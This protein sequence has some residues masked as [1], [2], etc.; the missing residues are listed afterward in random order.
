LLRDGKYNLRLQPRELALAATRST[1]RQ[2]H[3][4]HFSHPHERLAWTIVFAPVSSGGPSQ[5]L[6]NAPRVSSAIPD[7]PPCRLLVIRLLRS[8]LHSAHPQHFLARRPLAT[9]PRRRYGSSSHAGETPSF[10]ASP[11]KSVRVRCICFPHS[12]HSYLLPARMGEREREESWGAV[13]SVSWSGLMPSPFE[14]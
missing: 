10:G 4:R 6:L 3:Y 7:C 14:P 12:S 9:R 8:S 1:S 5:P 11:P 13:R 2:T